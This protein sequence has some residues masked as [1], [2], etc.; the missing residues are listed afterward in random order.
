MRSDALWL[1][2][3]TL[4]TEDDDLIE[5]VCSYYTI[6]CLVKALQDDNQ[7]IYKPG[8]K[9]VANLLTV[10]NAQIVDIA[11][12]S[13]LLNNL[14]S[15]AQRPPIMHESDSLQEICYCFSNIACTSDE[16]R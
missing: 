2:S 11:L 8:L 1:M 6:A 13:K 3:Y 10:D 9:A 15:L 4:D 7:S 16:S 12:S 14:L 5:Q